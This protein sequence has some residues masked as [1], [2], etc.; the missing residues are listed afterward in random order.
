V[1]AAFDNVAD[2]SNITGSFEAQCKD[3]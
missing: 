1:K 3:I 2:L